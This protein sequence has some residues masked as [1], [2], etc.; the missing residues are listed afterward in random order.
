MKKLF[1]SC[2]ILEDLSIEVVLE[3]FYELYDW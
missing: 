2:P 3:G 1:H